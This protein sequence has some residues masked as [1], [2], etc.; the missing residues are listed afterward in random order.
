M[1][2]NTNSTHSHNPATAHPPKAPQEKHW[3]FPQLAK[4]LL[5]T[6]VLNV[7]LWGGVIA[8]L[9]FFGPEIEHFLFPSVKHIQKI[10]SEIDRIHVI[11]DERGKELTALTAQ[12]QQDIAALKEA[13]HSLSDQVKAL[14]DRVSTPA[15]SLVVPESSEISTQWNILLKHFEKGEPFEEQLHALDPFIADNK[16][17]LMAVHA[18]VNE[19][20]KK[21]TT[22]DKLAA[23]LLIIKEKLMG[24]QYNTANETG[25]IAAK[26]SWISTL[27]EKAKS[28]ISLERTDQVTITVA[29]PTQKTALIKAIEQA[30]EHIEKHQFDAAIKTI[31][32]L[33]T[34]AKPAFDQWLMSAEMRLSIEQ[35]IEVLHQR[36]APILI[37]KV[38]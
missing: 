3:F 14:H 20:S 26:D 19:A 9:P 5:I 11:Q 27:W 37:K 17:T 15:S 34:Y 10:R 31:K 4:T 7:I 29:D 36:L 8:T 23:E 13:V 33:G 28:H 30:V 32:T 16:E 1:T 21:T 2:T 38:N 35:K 18:L 25:A 24:A 6:C 22:F 12:T